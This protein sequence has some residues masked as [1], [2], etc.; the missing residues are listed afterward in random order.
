MNGYGGGTWDQGETRLTAF[1]PMHA[2]PKISMGTPCG[3]WQRT[4]R[5]AVQPG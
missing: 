2:T 4:G 5:L 1:A 3:A